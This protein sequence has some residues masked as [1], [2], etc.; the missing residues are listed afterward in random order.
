[1]FRKK[2]LTICIFFILTLVV[3]FYYIFDFNYN[4]K[5]YPGV[6]V[7]DIN[8]GGKTLKE[9][10]D[11]L[12]VEIDK[13]NQN[14]VAFTYEGKESIIHPII[15]S[16]DAEIVDIL[17]YFDIE[18]TAN[19]AILFGRSGNFLQDIKDKFSFILN[20][21][22]HI[23]LI[24][25][26]D[27]ERITEF[28]KNDFSIFN[29]E[30]AE[31]YLNDD[32]TLS[33]KKE[34]RGKKINYTKAMIILEDNLS[35]LNF[36]DIIL[37]GKDID[38]DILESDCLSIKEK[39][40]GYL[41]I[42]P[43]KLIYSK[44]QWSIDKEN[45]LGMM[46]FLKNN[47]NLL[48]KLDRNKIERYIKEN[49]VPGIN[50]TSVLPK[51][52][53]KDGVIEKFEAGREGRELDIELTISLIENLLENPFNKLDLVVNILP[54]SS[55]GEEN[56]NTLGIK[57]IIGKYTLGFEGSSVARISNIKISA[58]SLNGL[59]IKP[60]EEFSMLNA[61]GTID[62]LNGYKKEAVIKNNSIIYEF[63][64]GLC[65]SSTTFFRTVLRAGLPVTMR[66]NHSYN[67]PYYQPP[68]TD[69]TIYN[70]Y[71]DFR[72][73][74]DTGEY[75]LIQAEATDEDLTIELWGVNDGREVEITDPLTYNIT[76]PL[77]VKIIGSH[78]LDF[79]KLECIYS[80]YDGIDAHFDYIVTYTSGE[81]KKKR[82]ESHY[83]PRQGVCLIGI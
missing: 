34:E 62:E 29:P 12:N 17:I 68:G 7:G 33:I 64:G 40:E 37:E 19:E 49:V 27:G 51:F 24:N 82:F 4:D 52:T 9:A 79:G 78:D 58:K 72:F 5:I 3:F 80:P 41:E 47:N 2:R 39:V 53:L 60:G 46:V 66:K 23:K 81:I 75:I 83:V 30:N 44:K 50:Q 13:I 71:L 32:G 74:N 22:K 55:D 1:M 54:F 35:A 16:S 70:P 65:H 25:N 11:L 69:A 31:Y 20:K 77:P 76:K 14:G 36:S 8:M 57:E 59:L 26:F 38:P 10:T 6:Y 43:I 15:S 67:M 45:F 73:V 42:A 48:I 28:L 18:K 21:S 63:G 56:E 61:L